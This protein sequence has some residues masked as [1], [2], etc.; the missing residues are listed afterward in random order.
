MM[1]RSTRPL[2]DAAIETEQEDLF[3]LNQ[4]RNSVKHGESQA[5]KDNILESELQ[6]S[7]ESI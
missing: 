3:N 4:G 5:K 1:D 6:M 7:D 2:I